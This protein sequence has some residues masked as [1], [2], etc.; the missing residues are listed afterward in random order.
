MLP[1]SILRDL[2]GLLAPGRR[3]LTRRQVY[4]LDVESVAWR[5]QLLRDQVA[6]AACGAFR[7]VKHPACR[8]HADKFRFESGKLFLPRTDLG[9]FLGQQEFH[10]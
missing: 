9:E 7:R 1:A 2:Y 3:Q 6:D 4:G 8:N 5:R 10:M